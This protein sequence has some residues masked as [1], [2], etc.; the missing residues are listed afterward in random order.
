[1]SKAPNGFIL[2]Q[3]PSMIDGAPI[4]AIACRVNSTSNN[5][6][7]GAMVQTFILRADRSPIDAINSG[8]DASICGHCPH[9]GTV[10]NGKNSG[11]S[12]Y[13]T[14][15]QAPTAVYKAYRRGIYPMAT[16]EQAQQW[17]AGKLVRLG[18]Y[19]DPGAVPVAVWQNAIA[20]AKAKNGYTHQWRLFPKLASMCMASCDTPEDYAA[21]KALGFRTFR[22]RAADEALNNREIACPASKEM[23]TR[24]NCA[25]CLACGGTS[26]KARVD[27]AIV[28]HGAASKINAYAAMRAA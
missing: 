19:G 11:R 14:V 28:A 26:A 16:P 2:Y 27:I 7:T 5:A 13:V 17:L 10:N 3:G 8:D 22:V 25:S 1:M 12:C 15:F 20:R 24:T 4:V 9:R 18:S 23:G 21:A 6:K